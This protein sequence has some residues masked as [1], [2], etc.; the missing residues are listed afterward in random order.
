MSN[1]PFALHLLYVPTE[2]EIYLFVH[3]AL[4]HTVFWPRALDGRFSNFV[5]HNMKESLCFISLLLHLYYFIHCL[6]FKTICDQKFHGFS[7][8]LVWASYHRIC[9]DPYHKS[10][11]MHNMS[12]FI[13]SWSSTYNVPSTSLRTEDNSFSFPR[14]K[15]LG[16]GTR[17]RLVFLRAL[18]LW[19]WVVTSWWW[20]LTFYGCNVTQPS[21]CTCLQVVSGVCLDCVNERDLS[22]YV[23]LKGL[24]NS[25]SSSASTPRQNGVGNV[26]PHFF[27]LVHTC[28]ISCWRKWWPL[29]SM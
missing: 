14:I 4:W 26:R 27:Q 2:P 24:S 3:R 1:V 23:F 29:M 17:D 9:A 16:G 7:S 18:P 10:C 13:F 20:A 19:W 22:L 25:S 5:M 11:W 15:L 28:A 6:L 12:S 8:H 21:P